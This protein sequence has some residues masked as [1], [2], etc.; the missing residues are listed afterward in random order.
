MLNTKMLTHQGGAVLDSS[1]QKDKERKFVGKESDVIFKERFWT[2]LV[3]QRLAPPR[4]INVL[5]IELKD[6]ETKKR[7]RP[8]ID[9]RCIDASRERRLLFLPM[10]LQTITGKS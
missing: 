2:Y 10:L 6:L 9:G 4:T 5:S 1:P 3:I 7:H 8:A